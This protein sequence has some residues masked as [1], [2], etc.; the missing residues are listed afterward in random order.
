MSD[1]RIVFIARA[2]LTLYAPGNGLGVYHLPA[3]RHYR[4][5]TY[6]GIDIWNNDQRESS[7]IPIRRDAASL[8]A[9]LC[10]HCA[11]RALVEAARGVIAWVDDP[12]PHTR[13]IAMRTLKQQFATLRAALE[14]LR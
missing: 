12:E 13:P 6:C 3:E 8:I 9:R 2:A 14:E 11:Y 10:A 5:R 4:T 1:T 7:V